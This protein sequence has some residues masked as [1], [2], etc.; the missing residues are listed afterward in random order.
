MKIINN[1]PYQA[2]SITKPDVLSWVA[3]VMLGAMVIAALV[4]LV[5][6]L[7]A[8]SIF[9]AAFLWG[10]PQTYFCWQSFRYRGASQT[11]RVLK[12]FQKGMSGKI[13]LT[14]LICAFILKRGGEVA[15]EGGGSK[16]RVP[17]SKLCSCI[18]Q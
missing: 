1:M 11:K 14:G 5:S 6:D 9:Y 15:F 16:F 13:V 7:H 3:W 4:S 2:N 10:V 12:A 8:K 17:S 18:V